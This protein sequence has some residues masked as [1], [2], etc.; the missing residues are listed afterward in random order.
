MR[1]TK[2]TA[3][4][5]GALLAGGLV[6][7][8]PA[9]SVADDRPTA[10]VSLGDSAISGEG[11]GDYEAGTRGENG[12]WCHRSA[13]ALVHRTAVADHTINLA[14]SGAE[15]AN[16]SLA[17]TTHYTEGSQAR[18]LIGIAQQYRVTTVVV[19]VGANDEPA[20]ADTILDCIA[21]WFNPF[22]AGCRKKLRT[23]WPQRVAAMA[24]R[25]EV[26]LADVRSAMS[27][28]GYADG[29]Y[30]LILTSYASPLTENMDA[31]LHGPQGCP[32]KLADAGYGRTEAV[33]Q[34]SEAL[35]GAATRSG[36]KFLDFSRATEGHEACSGGGDSSTEWQNRVK[37]DP[38]AWV[39]GGLDAIGIHMA[40]E[41][42][43]PN[44]RGHAQ[45]GRCVT[46]FVGSGANSARC[47]VG[48][49]GN[50]HAV[51]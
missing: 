38:W 3:L 36:A 21:E 1:S 43:H 40:Q 28:A 19:Q 2:I 8:S 24:P 41:S 37:V 34:L 7:A 47:L 4:A 26:A 33:P 44:A 22:G 18:R 9:A 50:V 31:T 46:E 11:A 5:L 16:V 51:Q 35:R 25:V 48:S 27:Q 12:N 32:F 23:E 15:A 10:I 13:N 39:T 14:C 20:F 6:V 30:N 49:D 45:L 17:D 42:F 29:S